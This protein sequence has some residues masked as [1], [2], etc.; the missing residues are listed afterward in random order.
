MLSLLAAAASDTETQGLI[1]IVGVLAVALAGA[2]TFSIKG[3]QEAKRGASQAKQ[4]NAAVN[5]VGPG[6][7]RLFDK[8]SH[9]ADAMDRIEA[10]QDQFDMKGWPS[11][12]SDINTAAGLTEVIRDLQHGHVDGLKDHQEI[13]GRL[14]AMDTEIKAHVLW[15]ETQKYQNDG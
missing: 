8:V 6:E 4:A 7:H 1:G 11:L 15:E 5:N 3:W 10:K 12:P 2:L 13:L 9:L 14:A